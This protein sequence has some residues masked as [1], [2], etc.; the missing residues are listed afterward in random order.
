MSNLN[1]SEFDKWNKEK[2]LIT[3]GAGFIGS[4]LARRIVD[5]GGEVTIV[6]SMIPEYGGNLFNLNGY[7]SKLN[8]N[9]SDIRDRFSMEYLLKNKSIIFHLAGQTSHLDSM[10][11]PHTDLE[12]NCVAQL[13][14][15]ESC[16]KVNPSAKIIF[17]STRQ[18]YG[19]P[20]YLPVNEDH[21]INPVDINGIHKY[22]SELYL[23][24]YNNIYDL[25]TCILRLTNTI[26][27]RMRIKDSRQTFL[28]IWIKNLI[29]GN[30]LEVWGGEQIRDFND[31]DDVVHALMICAK[32]QDILSTAYNLGSSESISLLELA[33]KLIKIFGKGEIKYMEYPKVRKKIDIGDYY[34]CYAKFN[35]V[36]GWEPKKNLDYTLEKT[37]N[38]YSKNFKFYK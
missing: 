25:R 3:G 12:I 1:F 28:G 30:P 21:K 19:K 10:I 7:E 11:N 5:L 34:S 17:T 9:F 23:K 27:P 2:V 20:N 8:I 33:E 31:V 36:T 35:N 4:N 18:I 13:S 6:D 16:R 15:L 29:Q 24:L 26:G 14:L 37:L 38:Y 32:N 22:A